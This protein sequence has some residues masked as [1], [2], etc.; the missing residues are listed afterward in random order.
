MEI[1]YVIHKEISYQSP[2]IHSKAWETGK[3][4][5]YQIFPEWFHITLQPTKQ[6]VKINYVFTVI[7]PSEEIKYFPKL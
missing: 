4:I 7:V 6:I 3:H 2:R 5:H 1:T